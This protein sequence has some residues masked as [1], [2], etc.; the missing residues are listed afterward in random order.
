MPA[1]YATLGDTQ[2]KNVR[3]CVADG[4]HKTPFRKEP[5]S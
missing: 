5:Q 2:S 1:K 3:Q 4:R